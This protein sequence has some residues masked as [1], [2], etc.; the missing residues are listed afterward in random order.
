MRKSN[1]YSQQFNDETQDVEDWEY[2]DDWEEDTIHARKEHQNHR[3]RGKGQVRRNIEDFKE[4]QQL[5]ELL[6]DDDD[7]DY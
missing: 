4:Q 2:E 6:G 1:N 3:G 7:L 5:R